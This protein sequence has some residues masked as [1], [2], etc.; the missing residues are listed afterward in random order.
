MPV[1]EKSRFNFQFMP[2]KFKLKAEIDIAY[3]NVLV[4][5]IFFA[6]PEVL[7]FKIKE[8]SKK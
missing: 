5:R 4:R 8:I 2:K 6:L 1:C 7:E 3:V